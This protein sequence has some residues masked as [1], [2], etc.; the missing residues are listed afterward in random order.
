[1]ILIFA[2]G[3]AAFYGRILGAF[4]FFLMFFLIAVLANFAAVAVECEFIN[5]AN[6]CL[7]VCIVPRAHNLCFV[8]FISLSS[9]FVCFVKLIVTIYAEGMENDKIVLCVCVC[10]CRC[11]A[12]S[13]QNI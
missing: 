12:I 10:A 3:S 5:L 6:C 8:F 9:R 2:L 1:M 4:P 11:S 7:F 13:K